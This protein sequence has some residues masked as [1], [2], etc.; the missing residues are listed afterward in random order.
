MILSLCL[1]GL[2]G[3]VAGGGYEF[4]GLE[5]SKARVLCLGFFGYGRPALP[6]G[7]LATIFK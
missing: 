7:W 3:L 2:I 6:T 4:G 1:V 5:S